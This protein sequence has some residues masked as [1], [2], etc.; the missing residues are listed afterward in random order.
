MYLK[1]DSEEEEVIQDTSK[2]VFQNTGLDLDAL[3]SLGNPRI[4]S[5]GLFQRYMSHYSL[6]LILPKDWQRH[7]TK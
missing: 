7:I 3:N 4:S 6:E 5:D 2:N 1:K